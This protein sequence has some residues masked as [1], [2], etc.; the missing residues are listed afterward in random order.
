LSTPGRV[1]EAMPGIESHQTGGG[2]LGRGCRSWGEV[3]NE[4]NTKIRRI[5]FNI[6]ILINLVDYTVLI[7][8][9]L[10]ST[11]INIRKNMK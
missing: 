5:I 11:Y 8:L 4:K 10:I 3:M 6:V 1:P 2:Q 7:N 9:I